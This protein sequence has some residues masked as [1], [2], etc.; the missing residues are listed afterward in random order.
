MV[1]IAYTSCKSS[2]ETYYYT[3]YKNIEYLPIDP[4]EYGYPIPVLE[5][6]VK[7]YKDMFL[8]TK[9]EK[10]NYLVN[11]N[12]LV[13]ILELTKDGEINLGP[14]ATSS[15]NKQYRIVMD[16]SKHKTL[17]NSS[18]GSA[19]IGVGLRLIAKVKSNK[20]NVGFGDLFALGIA[21]ESNHV[22]GTLAIEVIGIKSKDVTNI[23]PFPSEINPTTIQ[24]AMQAMAT[25]KSKI[26]DN[27]TQIF[28]QI[29]AIKL[30]ETN[31]CTQMDLIESLSLKNNGYVKN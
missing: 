9:E 18:L 26:Y 30:N 3:T 24:H 16:Y 8:A 13:T 15:K 12:V 4:L 21:A 14:S 1:L 7:K 22:K 11:E 10:L 31:N 25:I 19:R 27:T 17:N 2:S 6:N 20:S 23:I 29:I 28:P 5:N